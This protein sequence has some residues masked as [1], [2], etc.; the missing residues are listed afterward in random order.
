MADAEVRGYSIDEL[1][2]I[3]GEFTLEEIRALGELGTPAA[4]A[5]VWGPQSIA[6][7]CPING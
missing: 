2:A 7:S 4:I 5:T 1:V 3:F 6:F